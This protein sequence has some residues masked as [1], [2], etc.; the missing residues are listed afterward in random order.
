MQ[1]KLF[2]IISDIH[3][4]H[5]KDISPFLRSF[6][7]RP[8]ADYLIL[9]GDVCAPN[10]LRKLS[11]F[12][13]YVSP[14]YERIIYVLGNHEYYKYFDHTCETYYLDR[15]LSEKIPNMYRSV[16]APFHNV[17]LLENES[18]VD[19]HVS[20]YGTTLWTNIHGRAVLFMNDLNYLG[21]EEYLGMH[22]KAKKALESLPDRGHDIIVT[23]HM[24]SYDFVAPQYKNTGTMNSGFASHCDY[25]FP[26]AKKYWIFGH[27]HTPVCQDKDGIRF[28]CNPVGYPGEEG[29]GPIE[30]IVISL[31]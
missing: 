16:C 23:H 27:T 4:E 1:K 8:K 17:T 10:E 24:P 30:D 2:R 28:I 26:K 22:E 14:L 21:L 13:A 31:D 3:L 9:A 15:R 12:L 11:L 25:L 29:R 18:Y 7:A 19:E 5:H 20:I 6:C